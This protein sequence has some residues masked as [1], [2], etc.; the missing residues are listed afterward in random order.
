MK[1]LKVQNN[2]VLNSKKKPDDM[3]SGH[4]SSFSTFLPE[5]VARV[6]TFQGNLMLYLSTKFDKTFTQTMA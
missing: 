6:A 1:T 5:K 3:S 2:T 4:C